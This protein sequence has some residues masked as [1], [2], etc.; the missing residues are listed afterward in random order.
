MSTALRMTL[1]SLGAIA[2]TAV[3]Y[4]Q[5]TGVVEPYSGQIFLVDELN[6]IVDG[7][8]YCFDV[9]GDTVENPDGTQVHTCKNR[10]KPAEDQ[11]WIIDSP[12]LGNITVE[13]VDGLC[14]EATTVHAGSGLIVTTCSSSANQL[15]YSDG[16]GQIH[17]ASNTNLCWTVATTR[18]CGNP[19]CSNFKR[20]MELEKCASASDPKF[21]TWSIPGGTIGM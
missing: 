12:N 2:A 5:D 1:L 17:P 7:D 8:F 14:V 11:L 4:A 16:D 21:I 6:E 20:T 13:L 15:W 18:M 19:S 10:R 9:W 3:A